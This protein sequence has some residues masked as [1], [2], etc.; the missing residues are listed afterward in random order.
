MAQDP[1]TPERYAV[2]AMHA[3]IGAFRALKREGDQLD[4]LIEQLKV[5]IAKFD[6]RCDHDWE[7]YRLPDG[8]HGG[9][10][11]KCRVTRYAQ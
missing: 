7:A 11:K 1:K 6:P 4:N 2:E 10:C 3:A 9:T 5:A 8:G